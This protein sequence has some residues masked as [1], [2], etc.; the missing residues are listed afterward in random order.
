MTLTAMQTKEAPAL[1]K[2]VLGVSQAFQVANLNAGKGKITNIAQFPLGLSIRT[3]AQCTPDAAD[4]SA[5]A[6]DEFFIKA[7]PIRYDSRHQCLSHSPAHTDTAGCR[8]SYLKVLLEAKL[9]T[10]AGILWRDQ[11]IYKLCAL[12][13]LDC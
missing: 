10:C 6:F 13:P 3:L 4:R 2:A 7:G 11:G 1:Q 12:F 5:I 8:G 9:Q